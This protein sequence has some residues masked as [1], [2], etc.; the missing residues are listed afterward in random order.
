MPNVTLLQRLKD[1]DDRVIP[2]RPSSRLLIRH[3][4]R[5]RYPSTVAHGDRWPARWDAWAESLVTRPSWAASVAS[6]L[7]IAGI[8]AGAGSV[9]GHPWLGALA[10]VDVCP[11]FVFFLPL[12]RRRNTEQDR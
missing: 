9:A 4:E 6:M 10:A 12:R 3:S 2:P 5:W 7:F 1:L 8:G 11:V